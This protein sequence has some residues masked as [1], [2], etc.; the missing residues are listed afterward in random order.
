[1]PLDFEGQVTE[2]NRRHVV[3]VCGLWQGEARIRSAIAT[4]APTKHVALEDPGLSMQV[5][6]HGSQLTIRVEARSLARFVEVSAEGADVLFS[7]N[8]FDLPA[9]RLVSVT[10]PVPEG[11]TPE[12]LQGALRVRSVFDTY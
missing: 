12:Q 4:F 7:D 10:C 11:W 8:Y 5:G 2:E 1:L 3:L 9:G 6:Q